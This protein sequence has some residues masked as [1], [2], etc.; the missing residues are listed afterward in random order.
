MPPDHPF[1]Q[2][3]QD[4]LIVYRFLIDHIDKFMNIKPINIYLAGDSAGGNL[5]CSL[6]GLIL[7]NKLPTPRGLYLAYPATD[8]RMTF[9]PSK[10][11]ALTDILLWPSML[12]VCL[13]SYL[14]N[15]L[16]QV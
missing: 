2:A 14:S 13:K 15:K 8:L 3:P 16:E 9:S 7:K 11:N 4:C 12:L 6:T 10:I 1:P 5:A